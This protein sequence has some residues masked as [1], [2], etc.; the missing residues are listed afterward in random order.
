MRLLEFY[1]LTNIDITDPVMTTVGGVV[2]RLFGRLPKVGE[3]VVHDVHNYTVLQVDR[4]RIARLRVA[5]VEEGELEE[6]E[7]QDL[8]DEQE[9]AQ[10]EA[11][12]ALEAVLEAAQEASREAQPAASRT[13]ATAPVT[14]NP[15][16][17]AR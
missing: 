1:N 7:L 14:P 9:V 10:D 12:Q 3:S 15:T 6:Q 16:A 13:P 4:L 11:P 2:F 8:I 17:D 5:P